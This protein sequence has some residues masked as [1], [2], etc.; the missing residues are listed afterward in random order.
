M[1]KERKGKM[2]TEKFGLNELERFV[3]EVGFKRSDVRTIRGVCAI[4]D[5]P[6]TVVSEVQEAITHH[7]ED[8]TTAESQITTIKADDARNDE[9]TRESIARLRA[10]RDSS[11]TQNERAVVAK[12]HAIGQTDRDVARLQKLLKNFS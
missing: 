10:S 2:G 5:L 12:R 3:D 1:G 4:V 8:N 9:D 7:H 11:K 6:V